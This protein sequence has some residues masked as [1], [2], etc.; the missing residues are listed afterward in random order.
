M[1]SAACDCELS[2]TTRVKTLEEVQGSATSSVFTPPLF[3]NTWPCVQ[4]LFAECNAP[5]QRDLA[6]DFL[7]FFF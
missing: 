7:F 5:C 4:L 3:Q 6:I 1:L 2:T